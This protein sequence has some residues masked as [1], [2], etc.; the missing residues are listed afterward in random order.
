MTFIIP[1]KTNGNKKEYEQPDEGTHLGVLIDIYD[2]T[3]AGGT[4][5][6]RFMWHLAT[7]GADGTTHLRAFQAY[8]QSMGEGSHLFK[9]VTRLLGREPEDGFDLDTL[10]GRT[11]N[12]VLEKNGVFTNVTGFLKTGEKVAPPK[13]YVRVKDRDN[14]RQKPAT[15]PPQNCADVDDSD[16]G[17]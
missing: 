1:K 11:H 7:L 15:T 17:F 16:A 10:I 2:C 3:K 9:A 5:R 14:N 13:D 4:P 8:P 6:V 12:L